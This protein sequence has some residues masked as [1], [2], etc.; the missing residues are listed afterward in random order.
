MG[1]SICTIFTADF[2]SVE[3]KFFFSLKN[4]RLI[5]EKKCAAVMRRQQFSSQQRDFPVD[6]NS[7]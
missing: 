3:Q 6:N 1:L 2:I 5:L 7:N 4:I